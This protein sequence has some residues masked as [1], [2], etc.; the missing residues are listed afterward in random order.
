[1]GGAIDLNLLRVAQNADG[2]VPAFFA[3]PGGAYTVRPNVSVEIYAQIWTATNGVVNPRFVV[4]WGN[5]ERENTGCGSCRLSHTYPTAGTY[6]VKVI[7]DDRIS[8][9]TTRTFTLN[10]TPDDRPRTTINGT[11][12][13][14]DDVFARYGGYDFVAPAATVCNI[15]EAKHYFKRY[16][17]QHSGGPLDLTITASDFD[18]YLSVYAGSFSPDDACD[19]LVGANDDGAGDL[20]S[21]ITGNF[22]AGTYVV[23]VTSFA[24]LEPG[25]FTLVIQ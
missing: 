23:V 14:G 12:G 6:T 13:Q 25:S 1:V 17:I 7:L 16:V 21:R 2:G 3:F 15:S 4:E 22:G 18:T 11:L 9:T 20:R 5:G 10:V 19:N 8:S 24:P